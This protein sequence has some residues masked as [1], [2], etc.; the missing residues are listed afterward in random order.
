MAS[1]EGQITLINV[2]DGAGTPGAPGPTYILDTNQDEILRFATEREGFTFSPEILTIQVRKFMEDSN[3]IQS[4]DYDNLLVYFYSSGEWKSLDL[5]ALGENVNIEN[6]TMSIH[7]ASLSKITDGSQHELV[8]LLVS[9]ETALKLEYYVN[10]VLVQNKIIGIRYGLSADMARL[11]LN[12]EGIV[13]SIQDAGLRFDANGLTI[14]NGNFSI[15][16]DHYEP[17]TIT[18]FD[19]NKEYYIQ[20]ASGFE[21]VDKAGGIV[22]GQQ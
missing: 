22:E 1:Y 8:N 21:P 17:V 4:V 14:K 15:L 9:S 19:E 20:T 13:A 2:H 16:S 12:A 10:K 3:T 6:N 18:A 11:S 7:L 5:V